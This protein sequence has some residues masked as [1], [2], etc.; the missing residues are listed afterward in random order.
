MADNSRRVYS[1]D[2]GRVQEPRRREPPAPGPPRDGIVRVSR[3]SSGRRGKTVTLVTGLPPADL[4]AVAGEL[5]R[6]CGSGGAV[7]EG[8]VEIQGDHRARIVEH[9]GGRYR[10]KAAG[11]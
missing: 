3:T 7:K 1:T 9:L 10:V 2:G 8:T 11:G 6:L 4:R 5:K